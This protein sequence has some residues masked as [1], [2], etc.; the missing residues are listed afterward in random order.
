MCISQLIITSLCPYISLF[1]KESSNNNTINSMLDQK[2]Y[3]DFSV[4]YKP[5]F[6]KLY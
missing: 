1:I 4:Y 6:Y 3:I 5:F 2:N